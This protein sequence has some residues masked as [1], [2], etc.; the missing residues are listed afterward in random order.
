M[1]LLIKKVIGKNNY[2]FEFEGR[3]LHE[4]IMDSQKLSFNDVKECGI[5]KSDLL[6]LESHIAQGYKY[7]SIK[8]LKCNASVTFGQ[9]KDDPD[10]FYLRRNEDKTI[11]WKE[12]KKKS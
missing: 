8:C 6:I 5:C 9:K 10:T 7:T 1:K 12:F 2:T 4:V 11:E 3:N